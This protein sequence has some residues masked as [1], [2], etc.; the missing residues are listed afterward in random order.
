MENKILFEIKLTKM[1][2]PV[3][4]TAVQRWKLPMQ[5]LGRN[6]GKGVNICM[7]WY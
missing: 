7:D 4:T 6:V 5:E 1:A 3:R 2:C